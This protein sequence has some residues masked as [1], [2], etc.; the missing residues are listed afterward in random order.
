MLWIVKGLLVLAKTRRGRELLFAAGLT[1]IELAQ[2][3]RAR[4]LYAKVPRQR[5]GV[6]RV[7]ACARDLGNAD[8]AVP[9]RSAEGVGPT[10]E[11]AVTMPRNGES[12]GPERWASKRLNVFQLA[13]AARRRLNADRRHES[14]NSCVCVPLLLCRFAP[15]EPWQPHRKCG[16]ENQSGKPLHRE[17][18][19]RT[20]TIGC[21]GQRA[22]MSPERMMP[23][24]VRPWR[25]GRIY[26]GDPDQ[27]IANLRV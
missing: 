20:Y 21:L 5:A 27:P 6:T 8:E 25:S 26:T 17:S 24:E 1:A 18:Y 10:L 9:R 13:N 16:D 2:S 15:P 7:S 12:H 4:K 3:D 22:G 19:V 23:G 11:T 14:L